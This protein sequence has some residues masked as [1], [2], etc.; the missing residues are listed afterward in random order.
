MRPDAQRCRTMP[1]SRTSE[2]I[3]PFWVAGAR[4]DGDGVGLGE[5]RTMHSEIT[6]CVLDDLGRDVASAIFGVDGVIVNSAQATATAWKT[7][8]DP[9]LRSYALAQG[10][11]FVPF[12][13]P[14]DYMRYIHGRP[15]LEGA[16]VF[17]SSRGVTLPYD[18]LRGL[19]VRHEGYFLGEVHRRG[20]SPFAATV[21]L[22]RDLHRHGVR[23]AAV[24]ERCYGSELLEAAGAAT[25]F[26]VTL[27]GTDTLGTTLRRIPDAGPYGEAARRLETPPR[28]TAVI[29]AS[30]SGVAA[31][32]RGGF[33]A[34][35]G[36][37][38]TGGRAGL[39][40]YGADLVITDTSE[41]RWRHRRVA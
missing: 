37:D 6:Q 28:L 26:D 25:M 31:A 32:R 24:S 15:R 16:R 8:L 1:F 3:R 39:D 29:E 18:D 35:V 38:P 5:L 30:A 22:V 36:V 2:D 34:I 9:F 23:T 14:A 21:A 27:D 7:V 10:T 40:R 41:L 12:D 11:T 19:A 20:V 13:V 33:G 17:L 4:E